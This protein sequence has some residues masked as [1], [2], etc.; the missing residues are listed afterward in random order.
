MSNEPSKEKKMSKEYVV[1][2]VIEYIEHPP[3]T[4]QS[5][6]FGNVVDYDSDKLRDMIDGLSNGDLSKLIEK[7][8]T[9]TTQWNSLKVAPNND[10]GI[11]ARYQEAKY[12]LED[13]EQL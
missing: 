7:V 4:G 2:K 6:P 1:K 13:K 9:V 5:S 10:M 3:L 12:F 8:T 11:V